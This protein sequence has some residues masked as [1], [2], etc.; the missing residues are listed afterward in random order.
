MRRNSNFSH[1]NSGLG[2]RKPAQRPPG[3]GDA[4]PGEHGANLLS[5]LGMPGHD[6]GQQPRN[7]LAQTHMGAGDDFVLARMGAGREKHRPVANRRLEP[8]QIAQIDR[9][10]RRVELDAASGDGLP[11]AQ[12][13]Q[14]LGELPVLGQH[15]VE[16][17]KQRTAQPRA[18]PPALEGARR[19]AGVHQRQR[20]VAGVRTP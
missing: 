10:R 19:H 8:R 2:R 18:P 3:S 5:P 7:A 14:L 4:E 16:G 1:V 9:R 6:D 15:D 11:R 13:L 20:N 17:G 12:L